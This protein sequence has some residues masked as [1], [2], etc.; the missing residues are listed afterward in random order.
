MKIVNLN[1]YSEGEGLRNKLRQR[2]DNFEPELSDSLWDR[3]HHE[4][5]QKETQRKK[6]I[7]WWFTSVAVVVLAS[8]IATFTLVNDNSQPQMAQQPVVVSTPAPVQSETSNTQ[9]PQETATPATT[10]ASATESVAYDATTPNGTG[11]GR[12]NGRNNGNSTPRNTAP[13]A[14]N[15]PA[16]VPAATE[17]RPTT[18]EP[19]PIENQQEP[20]AP[21]NTQAP[22]VDDNS[23]NIEEPTTPATETE[24]KL[25]EKDTEKGKDNTTDKDTKAKYNKWFIG[26]VY[27]YAQNNRTV[28]DIQPTF[29]WASAAERNKYEH[30]GIATTYGIQVGFMATKNVFIKSGVNIYTA[31][32]VVKY[33]IHRRKFQQGNQ[34]EPIYGDK[35]DSVAVGTT[36][37]HQN[38]YTYI[39]IP[40]EVGF[41]HDISKRWGFNLSAGVAYNILNNYNYYLYE[42]IFGNAFIPTSSSNTNYFQNY[43]MVSGNAG[44]HYNIS[45]NW[46]ALAGFNYRKAVTSAATKE[47]HVDV[48]P[49]SIGGNVALAFSF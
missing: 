35:I 48:R 12:N 14:E 45:K 16:I 2:I 3:I 8:G 38:S 15:S 43:V 31:T 4:M 11:N 30:S 29:G 5:D 28:T 19:A 18:V 17:D 13:V 44:L 1:E 47:T 49:W 34:N 40:L 32:E 42:P 41:M 6:R 26:A 36:T 37:A 25:E 46:R 33:D 22:I 20:L 7:L 10:E 39:Q 23:N 24:E 21:E 9:M 27:G